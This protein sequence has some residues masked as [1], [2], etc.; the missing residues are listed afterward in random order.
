MNCRLC[1]PNCGLI[2]DFGSQAHS[3]KDLFI[4]RSIITGERG[5]CGALLGGHFASTSTWGRSRG[6]SR[7]RKSSAGASLSRPVFSLVKTPIKMFRAV[8]R[9]SCGAFIGPPLAVHEPDWFSGCPLQALSLRIHAFLDYR[10][11][12]S[13]PADATHRGLLLPSVALRL[14]G[15]SIQH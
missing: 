1:L 2:D 10:Y 14:L 8:E 9:R 4:V 5:S 13:H 15:G 12:R 3:S 11:S 7:G 6:R